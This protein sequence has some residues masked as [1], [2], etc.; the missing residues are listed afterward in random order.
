MQECTNLGEGKNASNALRILTKVS[1]TDVTHTYANFDP[2][3]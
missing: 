2:L 1:V 3:A